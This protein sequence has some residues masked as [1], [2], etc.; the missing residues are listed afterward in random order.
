MIPSQ[1][2]VYYKNE[3]VGYIKLHELVSRPWSL[4]AI[5]K[6]P[7]FSIL[8]NSQKQYNRLCRFS[9]PSTVG[10]RGVIMA[11]LV[12]RVLALTLGLFFVFVGTIKLTP[13]VNTEIYKEMVKTIYY[14]SNLSLFK[15]LLQWLCTIIKPFCNRNLITNPYW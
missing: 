3:I 8:F 5:L 12:L 1:W 7:K 4:S 10:C 2:Y 9:S 14:F 6:Q 15:T 13:S 11:S